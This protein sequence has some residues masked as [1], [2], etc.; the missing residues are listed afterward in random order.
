MK[1]NRK[2]TLANNNIVV[3]YIN[4]HIISVSRLA[5][6]GAIL[7]KSDFT[8][9]LNCM[10]VTENHSQHQI[11]NGNIILTYIGTVCMGKTYFEVVYG[12]DSDKDFY[13]ATLRTI[14]SIPS[15]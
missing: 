13:Q 8:K 10:D 15:E 6:A 7:E 4:E 11:K 12:M 9:T 5:V 2:I 1:N 14:R 3:E